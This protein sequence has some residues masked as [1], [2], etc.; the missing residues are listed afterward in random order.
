MILRLENASL[1]GEV[2][3]GAYLA[4]RRLLAR[5]GGFVLQE[6]VV[7]VIIVL[8]SLVFHLC[9]ASVDDSLN[10]VLAQY[11]VAL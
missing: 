9:W 1:R 7:F 5:E 6:K 3:D 2:V 10:R 4:E 11:S 8:R